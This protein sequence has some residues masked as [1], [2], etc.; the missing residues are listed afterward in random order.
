MV[1]VILSYPPWVDILTGDNKSHKLQNLIN[2]FHFQS[3]YH[4]Y[5]IG[6]LQF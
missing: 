4:I 1:H 3:T 5:I 2:D 6:A